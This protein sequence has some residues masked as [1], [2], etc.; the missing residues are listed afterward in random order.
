MRMHSLQGMNLNKKIQR[1]RE[2]IR[3]GEWRRERERERG[4]VDR[5]GIFKAA[6]R[7]A[8]LNKRRLYVNAA[9]RSTSRA[10]E[11]EKAPRYACLASIL[12]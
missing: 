6:R 8:S 7:L 10:E 9:R 11:S 5:S 1:E 3:S 2:G 12:T 4:R